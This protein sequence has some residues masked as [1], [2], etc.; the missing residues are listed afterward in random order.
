M[1]GTGI[2][3]GKMMP[4]WCENTLYVSGKP[5]EIDDFVS[6]IKLDDGIYSILDSLYPMPK[7]LNEYISPIIVTKTEI[8]AWFKSLMYKIKSRVEWGRRETKNRFMS[9]ATRKRLLKL[10]SVDNW[11]DW[12]YFNWGT[13]WGDCGTHLNEPPVTTATA[14]GWEREYV[15]CF[16]SP[17]GPP[18]KGIWHL[19]KMFPGLLFQLTYVEYGMCFAGEVI[20]TNGECELDK[21]LTNEEF[22]EKYGYMYDYED[23]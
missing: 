8:G 22:E 19:S 15:F 9:R 20:F 21:V 1:T 23:N 3:K 10:Y 16:D 13:K 5:E 17:W 11:Y 7:E 12:Q 2:K 14:D 4:N 18:G 6:K